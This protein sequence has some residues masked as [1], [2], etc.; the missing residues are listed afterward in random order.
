MISFHPSY[1]FKRLKSN[2]FYKQKTTAGMENHPS[3]SVFTYQPLEQVLNKSVLTVKSNELLKVSSVLLS[4]LC[5]SSVELSSS[6]R[7]LE[8]K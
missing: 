4:V 8:L 1:K 7:I 6:L 5:S 3:G 2:L